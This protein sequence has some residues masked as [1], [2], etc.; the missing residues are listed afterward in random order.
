ML[1]YLIKGASGNLRI[2]L[3][4]TSFIRFLYAG[5]NSAVS[6]LAEPTRPSSFV[7]KTAAVADNLMV[8]SRRRRTPTPTPP[9]TVT[10]SPT[11]SAIPTASA[12]PTPSPGCVQ[13]TSPFVNATV[14]GSSVAITTQDSCVG[15]WFETLYVDGAFVS[16][17]VTGQVV[18]NSTSVPNGNHLL[19]VTSQSQNP[20]S[21]Q[22]GSA[23]VTLNV[24][25]LSATP[26]PTPVG[27]FGVAPSGITY[28]S[29]ALCAA[30]IV[31]TAETVVNLQDTSCSGATSSSTTSNAPF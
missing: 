1:E 5:G 27:F 31:S 7:G 24:Q 22:L 11:P 8:A 18:F 17:F 9:P 15:N 29:D 6:V 30:E 4:V 23:I 19:Q 10:L 12:T 28:P 2:L 13:I 21:I 26:T 20:G 14:S 16:A 25:N 3:W